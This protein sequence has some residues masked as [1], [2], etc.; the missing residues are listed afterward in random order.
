MTQ[1]PTAGTPAPGTDERPARRIGARAVRMAA[2]VLAVLLVAAVVTAVVL[3]RKAEAAD[4]RAR[5]SAAAANVA[6]QFALRMDRIDGT[7]FDGYVKGVNELLTTKARTENQKVFATIKQ[8]YEA[9]RVKGTGEVLLTAVGDADDD[10]AT[11][12]VV[13]DA[14]VT[15]TQGKIE[16]HYRWTVN[17]V[18]VNGEWL[19]DDFTPVS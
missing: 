10:S 8:G 19:V 17:V 6:E 15:T 12:L 2:V 5:E 9:A 18:K 13:H 3:M 7:D 1:A 14:D 16:H 11:I 4:D